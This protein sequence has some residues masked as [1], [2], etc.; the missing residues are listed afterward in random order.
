MEEIRE[1]FME[2]EEDL[3]RIIQYLGSHHGGEESR[4]Y[5]QRPSFKSQPPQ[6]R[7]PV[8]KDRSYDL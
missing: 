7:S 8:I 3:H 5:S 4:L 2:E 6:L 1:D